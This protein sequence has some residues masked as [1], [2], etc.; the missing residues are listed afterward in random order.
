M[1]FINRVFNES[2]S[3]LLLNFV[4][5]KKLTEGDIDELKEII[6]SSSKEDDK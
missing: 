3:D 4:K 6:N 5:S 1:S 2:F